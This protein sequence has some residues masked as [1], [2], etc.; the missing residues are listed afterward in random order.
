MSATTIALL[1]DGIERSQDIDFDTYTGPVD[2][3]IAAGIIERHHLPPQL[4]RPAHMAAFFPDG[5]PVPRGGMGMPREAGHR[6]IEKRSNGKATVRVYVSAEERRM[7]R[8]DAPLYVHE[9]V[10]KYDGSWHGFY[11]GNREQLVA[12]GFPAAWMDE[13]KKNGKRWTK[14]T[15]RE[16]G[17]T[18]AIMLDPRDRFRIEITPAKQSV[19]PELTAT[20]EPDGRLNRPTRSAPRYGPTL[21][22]VWSAP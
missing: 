10:A 14:R 3:L 19:S 21:R 8:C 17:R 11:E 4:G 1:P 18:I 22:L 16:P 12:H 15:I 6:I 7:R 2:A 5:S 9:W 20:P 13:T